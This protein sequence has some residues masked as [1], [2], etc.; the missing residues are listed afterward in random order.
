MWLYVAV[1]LV[2]FVNSVPAQNA[3]P[4]HAQPGCAHHPN[5]D[6]LGRQFQVATQEMQAGNLDA[7]EHGFLA[8]LRCG[9]N[10]SAYA[11]LGVVYMRKHDWPAA[12]RALKQAERLDPGM[13]GIRLNLAL[14]AFRRSRYE[15]AIPY[16][17]FLV[18]KEPD[19]VQPTFL[20][21]L[22]YFFTDQYGKAALLLDRL[23]SSQSGDLTYL[24][25][26]GLAADKS[27]Q[28][29]LSEKA[30]GRLAD[31]GVNSAQFH[32][33]MGRAFY[34]RGDPDKAIGEFQT[35]DKIDPDLPFLH[36]H[37]GRAYV[38]INDYQKAKTQFLEDIA[39]EPDIPYA[40]DELGRVY[41]KLGDDAAAEKSFQ[42]ALKLDS[43]LAGAYFGLAKIYER[44]GEVEKALKDID[45]AL[46][47]DPESNNLHYMRAR[48]LQRSG[49]EAKAKL[50][51]AEAKRLLEKHRGEDTMERRL[52]N[53]ELNL[54]TH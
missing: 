34:N 51:F 39:L 14:V 33:L 23:W 45:A 50:E 4:V 2:M 48:L 36:Y 26:L 35:A 8:L 41:D 13:Q 32:M 24:Y 18:R 25:V 31:V 42:T 10:A 3:A 16:L 54:M 53:P 27:Q 12:T 44:R 11:N 37:W 19:A 22:C 29:A 17:Q 9:P 46:K 38:L 7:A 21:G 20:L 28:K 49:Q 15:E 47:M 1:L 5:N 6:E 52:A 30:W 43:Q 40:Y